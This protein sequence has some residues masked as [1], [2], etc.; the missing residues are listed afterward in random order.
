MK[1]LNLLTPLV[2]IRRSR[3]GSPAVKMWSPIVSD[4]MVSGSGYKVPSLISAGGDSGCNVVEED[5]ESSISDR[6]DG[7]GDSDRR[8]EEVRFLD[9]IFCVILV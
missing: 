5:T 2:R 4:V 3:G 8:G 1:S 9:L 7:V 6:L